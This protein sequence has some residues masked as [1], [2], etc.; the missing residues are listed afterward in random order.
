MEAKPQRAEAIESKI[1]VLRGQR[2]ML[3][4]DLAR[5][6]SV[7]VRALNQAV[8]RNTER[9]PSDFVFRLEPK[10]VASLRSQN[11][12]LE[13]AGRGRYAKYRPYAFTE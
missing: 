13:S 4:G 5:L 3:D 2:V 10:E 11:V 8:K 12:I 1:V 7:E 6:Y 9:F